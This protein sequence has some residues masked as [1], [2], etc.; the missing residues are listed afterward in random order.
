[1][2][3]LYIHQVVTVNI[4]DIATYAPAGYSVPGSPYPYRRGDYEIAKEYI[5]GKWIVTREFAPVPLIPNTSSRINLSFD[6]NIWS[7]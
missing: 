3:D 1:M 6:F 4:N 5:N 7:K 2:F